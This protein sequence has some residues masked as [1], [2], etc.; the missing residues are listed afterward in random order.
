M[1]AQVVNL[2]EGRHTLLKTPRPEQGQ[3]LLVEFYEA[4][5]AALRLALP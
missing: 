3:G 1:R 4:G 2:L 5:Q